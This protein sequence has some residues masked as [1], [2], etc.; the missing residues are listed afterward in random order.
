[1]RYKFKR[2]YYIYIFLDI[3][4]IFIF[5]LFFSKRDTKILVQTKIHLIFIIKIFNR[6]KK[7]KTRLKC[8]KLLLIIG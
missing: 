8:I 7:Y 6:I 4:V 5:K 3:H 1:M 2:N